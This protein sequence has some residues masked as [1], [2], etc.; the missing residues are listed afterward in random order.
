MLVLASALAAIIPMVTY[1]IVIWRFDRYDR[2]PIKLVITSYLWGAI[3]AIIFAITGGL[4]LSFFLSLLTTDQ[5]EFEKLR[6]ILI[7]PVVEEITKGFFL[8]VV[9]NNHKFDNLTDGIVYGGAIGLGF[10]MTENFL[11]FV[12]Y[13]S[14]LAGWLTIV[15]MRSLF[16]AVMHCISTATLGASFGLAKFK[17][18]ILKIIYPVIGLIAAMLI[19]FVWNFSVSSESTALLGFLFMGI[20]IILFI[21]VFSFSVFSE[22]KIIF[23]QLFQE[24]E[25]GIIPSDHLKILSSSKRNIKG[26]IN[27]NIRKVYIKSA[28]SLA[29]KKM[30]L[31]KSRGRSREFYE[32]DVN[33][34]REFI[35]NLLASSKI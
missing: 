5:L 17:G 26:W 8:L 6:T 35:K 21:T 30:H 1:L 13:G 23:S 31:E 9:I 4:V 32:R 10:G 20:T 27:E 11:Y 12:S 2:E 14:T 33:N 7:A 34:Y 3:G 28:T 25:I 18:K 19:H 24:A 29:F 15:I 16:S 22:K